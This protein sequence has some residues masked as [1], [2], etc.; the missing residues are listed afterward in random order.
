MPLYTTDDKQL[1]AFEEQGLKVAGVLGPDFRP[2]A[3]QVEYVPPSTQAGQMS[4]DIRED[5]PGKRGIVHSDRRQPRPGLL[6]DTLEH[7]NC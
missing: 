1:A 4:K 2:P 5:C 7:I 3:E 6:A